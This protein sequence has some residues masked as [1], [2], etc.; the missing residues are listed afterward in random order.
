[1]TRASQSPA[2]GAPQGQTGLCAHQSW[3]SASPWGT[4]FEQPGCTTGMWE[5]LWVMP[6][7][8]PQPAPPHTVLHKR[9]DVQ[10]QKPLAVQAT[11]PL[12]AGTV[13]SDRGPGLPEVR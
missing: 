13:P 7:L 2:G 4:H 3:T 5:L 11:L 6:A 12:L 9:S 1:M 8:E 10:R